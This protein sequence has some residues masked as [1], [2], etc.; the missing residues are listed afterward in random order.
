MLDDKQR[1]DLWEYVYNDGD[2]PRFVYEDFMEQMPYGTA[3]A[4]DGDPDNWLADHW[5]RVLDYYSEELEAESVKRL[6]RF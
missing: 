1:Q 5:D 4:R 6:L 2:T 3:K